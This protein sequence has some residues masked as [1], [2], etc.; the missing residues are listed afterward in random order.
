MSYTALYR[1]WRP[2]FFN[3]VKGQEAVVRTLKNQIISW[4]VGHAYLFCGSRG[5][6]KTSVAKIF[7]RAVN[8]ENP[9]DGEPCCECETCKAI[10]S[11]ASMNVFEI[12][13]ASNNGVDFIRQIEE[14]IQYPPTDGRYKV[15]IVDEVH[16]LSTSAFNAFLKTLEEP[17]AYVI[18]VLATTEPHKLPATI[19]SRCQKYDF[20]RIGAD[21][22]VERLSD[23]CKGESIQIEERALKY[24]ARK[25]DG[26]LRD[27][28]SLLDRA[29]VSAGETVITYDS[30]LR[31]L[32]AVDN[33]VFSKYL[34]FLIDRNISGMLS[35]V[36]EVIMSGREISQFSRDF[37]WYLRNVLLIKNA[38]EQSELIDV[39][40]EDRE[41]LREEAALAGN[42]E[43]FRLIR[44]YSACCNEMRQAINKRVIFEMAAIRSARPETETDLEGLLARMDAVEARLE[45][46]ISSAPAARIAEA[47][48]EA[49]LTPALSAEAAKETEP[50]PA[51]KTVKEM[52]PAP[53][54][55][56]AAP[57]AVTA[58][59]PPKAPAPAPQTAYAA[60]PRKESPAPKRSE[61]ELAKIWTE[62][63]SQQAVFGGV[64]D[65]CV[66]IEEDGVLKVYFKDRFDR[67]VADGLGATEEIKK[68]F[69]KKTGEENRIVFLE[70]TPAIKK[71]NYAQPEK[72][73]VMDTIKSVF[74]GIEIEEE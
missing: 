53:Q 48:K 36:D 56:Y 63:I 34:R 3:D 38:P 4:R 60:E 59:E 2:I 49:E 66:R 14:E 16:M 54:T 32:G 21:T 68:I 7:A 25:A 61:G 30:A 57:A 11:G 18:F 74:Q 5:T 9:K 8:C 51:A 65:D 23:L 43:L 33:D 39:S 72:E 41:K 35:L 55:A 52:E 12:D 67:E 26:G 71:S 15:Y 27:A 31:S 1:K 50:T 45:R 24:I 40:D 70:G 10:S 20:R 69:L 46:G 44:I 6:G 64:F 13:A 22:I 42:D 29:W 73:D 28:I 17:P 37:T 47:A 58:P 62:C 19:L